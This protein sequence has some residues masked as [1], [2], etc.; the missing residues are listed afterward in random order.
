MNN[1]KKNDYWYHTGRSQYI[2]ILIRDINIRVSEFIL[3][4]VVFYFKIY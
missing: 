2:S 3:R 1:L 4:I